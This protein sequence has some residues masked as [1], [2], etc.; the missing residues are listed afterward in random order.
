VPDPDRPLDGAL[1]IQTAVCAAYDETI[2]V[3][4]AAE[5]ARAASPSAY[6]REFKRVFGRPGALPLGATSA[7]ADELT[8]HVLRFLREQA[9]AAV[10]GDPERVVITIPVSWE[11][12]NRALMREAAVRA[13]YHEAIIGLVPE[14]VAAVAAAFGDSGPVTATPLTVLVYDLGGGTFDC[15]LALGTAD[16]FDVLS[17]PGGIDNLGGRDFDSLLLGLL[18]QRLGPAVKALAGTSAVDS[19]DADLLARRLTLFDEAE[20]IKRELSVKAACNAVLTA[21]RP[22]ASVRVER[23]EFEELI[24]PLLAETVTECERMLQRRGMTWADIDR[25]VPVGGSSNIPLV[26]RMLADVSGR[27]VLRLADPERAVVNG[28]ARIARAIRAGSQVATYQERET[29]TDTTIE[30][31]QDDEAAAEQFLALLKKHASKLPT[32]RK[33]NI[34]VCGGTGAGKTTTINTLFGREVGHIGYFSRGTDHDELYEWESHGRNIDVVD[35]PGLG[36]TKKRD[37]EYREMYR[38]RVE[39]ADGFIV[40]VS[41][42][43]PASE[44]TLS[45]VKVLLSCG[46]EPRRIVFAYN[47]LGTLMVPLRGRMHQVT[48]DGLAGPASRDDEQIIDEA[49]RAFNAD[50]RK[51]IH[52]GRYADQFP[53][54]RVVAY[55]ALS[56]WNLFAVLGAVLETLPGDSLVKWRDAVARAAQ[57]LQQRTEKRIKKET[58]EHRRQVEELE[59]ENKRLADELNKLGDEK[60]AAGKP[61][62]GDREREELEREWRALKEKE[63]RLAGD[64]KRIENEQKAVPGISR[65]YDSHVES[66]GEKFVKWAAPIVEATAEVARATVNAVKRGWRKLFG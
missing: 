48:L 61:S 8:M 51:E 7:T 44:A 56:G 54:D 28:A 23:A 65:Q 52:G 34:L 16:Q 32:Q 14:P 45:C 4:T 13:G 26:G 47:N 17:D 38:R 27:A 18:G 2:L 37:K 9:Q 15:C 35:L 39:K 33:P 36:D 58:A 22:A 30:D 21:T 1:S 20:R 49:R 5:Y 46:V 64:G 59:K 55:D 12:G 53:L 31:E 50:I 29:M 66:V 25:V 43:R 60:K 57:D 19:G 62:A 40:V 63:R 41:R 24:R 3:G 42:P 6:R 10:P 11:A